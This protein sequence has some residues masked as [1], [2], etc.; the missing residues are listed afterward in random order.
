MK[1]SSVLVI[2]DNPDHFELL[3]VAFEMAGLPCQLIHCVD[4]ETGLRTIRENHDSNGRASL[5]DLITL[6]LNL[7]GI[8]GHAVLDALKT[9]PVTRTVPVIVMTSSNA[10]AD[11]RQAYES[12]ANSYVCKPDDFD[13]LAR[14]ASG[15]LGY[16]C[17]VDEG[18]LGPT[19]RIALT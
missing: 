4:G 5:P 2:E 16:W 1:V 7:P 13:E 15:L 6:D 3:S 12:H 17:K 11:R 18:Y 10:D 19:R 8:Q 14:I 9:D